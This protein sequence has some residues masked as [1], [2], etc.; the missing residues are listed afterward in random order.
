MTH[1]L[2]TLHKNDVLI[3]AMSAGFGHTVGMYTTQEQHEY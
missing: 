1:R 3:A 2:S